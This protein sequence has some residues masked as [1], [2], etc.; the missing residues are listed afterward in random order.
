MAVIL[1]SA[2]V[3]TSTFYRVSDWPGAPTLLDL[4]LWQNPL[5]LGCYKETATGQSQLPSSVTTKRATGLE[6]AT[7]SLGS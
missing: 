6:P 3:A 1:V 7:L 5:T 2:L 4:L